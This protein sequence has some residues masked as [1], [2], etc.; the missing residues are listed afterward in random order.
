MP[1]FE[2][3]GGEAK[4]T[5][6]AFQHSRESGSS[7]PPTHTTAFPTVEKRVSGAEFHKVRK[8]YSNTQEVKS[9][10][11][12]GPL[13]NLVVGDRSPRRLSIRCSLDSSLKRPFRWRDVRGGKEKQ[14]LILKEKAT[15]PESI[16]TSWKQ[17][18]T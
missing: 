8:V 18:R 14:D 7:A 1:D 6:E 3:S 13:K 5:K 12:I 15:R 2:I 11:P 17:G 9:Q 4:P 16:R 10:N